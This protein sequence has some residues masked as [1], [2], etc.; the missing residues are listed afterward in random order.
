MDKIFLYCKEI[1]RIGTFFAH[2]SSGFKIYLKDIIENLKP[3]S[4][5]A[6]ENLLHNTR[7]ILKRTSDLKEKV[8]QEITTEKTRGY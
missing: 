6:G 7:I 3:E 2:L 1:N 8:L 5:K 4:L